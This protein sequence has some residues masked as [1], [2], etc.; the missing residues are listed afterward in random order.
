MDID[1]DIPGEN[2]VNQ[3]AFKV[4]IK[5]E[6]TIS[7]A[8]LNEAVQGK[9]ILIPYNAVQALDVIFRHFPSMK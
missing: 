9:S 1:V 4:N 6:K 7:L 5:F 3:R 2:H 8:S